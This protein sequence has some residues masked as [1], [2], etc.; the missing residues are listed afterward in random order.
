MTE[1]AEKLADALTMFW[2]SLD[3]QERRLLAIGGLWLV[4][5]AVSVPMEQARRKRERDEL[6]AA[7]VERLGR[8]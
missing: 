5:V 8:G 6:V 4:G 1:I 2:Q 7:V 3:T